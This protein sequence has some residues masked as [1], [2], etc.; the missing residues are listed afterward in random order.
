MS[1]YV[2]H[3]VAGRISKF[4][5]GTP[6]HPSYDPTDPEHVRRAYKL[7]VDP[8]GLKRVPGYFE[9]MLSRVRVVIF[10]WLSGLNP[11][12]LQGT[13]VLEDR[14][15]RHGFCC[16]SKGAP[17]KY[18]STEIVKYTGALAAPEWG[19]IEEGRPFGF[20]CYLVTS[21]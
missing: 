2:D 14:E 7:Y 1:Y 11:V 20:S 6:C 21:A 4:T 17:R 19:D 9:T 16:T 13:K 5:Y 12:A 10:P 8:M 15:I 3:F 18:V